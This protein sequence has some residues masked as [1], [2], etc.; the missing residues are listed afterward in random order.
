LKQIPSD[1]KLLKQIYKDYYKTFISFPSNFPQIKNKYFIPIDFQ[2][3]SKELNIDPDI[4]VGRLFNLDSKYGFKYNDASRINLFIINKTESI[5][6]NTIN[7]PLV[8]TILADLIDKERKYWV[9][10][11]ISIFSLVLSVFS[12]LY[13]YQK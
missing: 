13:S 8:T 9:P 3:I 7:F 10:I 11:L 12:L 5:D 4:I 2:R 6:A 1:L